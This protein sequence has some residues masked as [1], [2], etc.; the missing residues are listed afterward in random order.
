M[1]RAVVPSRGAQHVVPLWPHA[2][3]APSNET[4]SAEDP[5]SGAFE[6]DAI[7]GSCFYSGSCIVC[8]A[9]NLTIPVHGASDLA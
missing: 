2:G 3:Q 1:R 5:A 9:W 8:G 7:G 6:P 4:A